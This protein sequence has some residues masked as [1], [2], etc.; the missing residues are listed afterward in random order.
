LPNGFRNRAAIN[1]PAGP[2]P[3]QNTARRLLETV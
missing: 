2:R 3:F 1:G